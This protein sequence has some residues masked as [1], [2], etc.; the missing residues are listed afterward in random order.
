MTPH[1]VGM[2]AW[3]LGWA[4]VGMGL[5][6]WGIAVIVNVKAVSSGYSLADN[7]RRER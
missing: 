7:E 4:L 3:W 2:M 5:V 1:H 6:L